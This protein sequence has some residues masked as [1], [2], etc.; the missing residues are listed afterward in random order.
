MQAE[1]SASQDFPT[2]VAALPFSARAAMLALNAIPLAHALAVVGVWWMPLGWGARAVAGAAVLYLLPPFLARALFAVFGKPRG[3][4]PVAGSPFMV[5]WA[6]LQLQMVFCR[7]PALEEALRMLPGCY[8]AWLRLWG[9]RVGR[10]TYW[11]PGTMVLDRSYLDVGDDVSLG[12]G[13]RLNGHVIALSES[14]AVE[15]IVD[16]IFL[17]AGCSVGGYC[18]LTAGARVAPGAS[19]RAALSLPPYARWGAGGRDR[20]KP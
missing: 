10:L 11:A 4:F 17:G 8:S 7:F 12:A 9:S 16:D 13:V 20:Q 2:L 15:L 18:L 5:W 14:G 3:R 19:T 1:S 6:S